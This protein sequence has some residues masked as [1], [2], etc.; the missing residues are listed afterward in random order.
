MRCSTTSSR[1]AIIPSGGFFGARACGENFRALLDIHPPYIDPVSSLAGGYMVNFLSYRE[2]AVESRFR[3]FPSARS[4]QNT[5]K[6][7][8]GIGAVQ[9]FCQ[10][11]T[12]GFTLGWGGCSRRSATI[13][14]ST[15]TMR[16]RSS[17]TAWSTSFSGCRAGSPATPHAARDM[18]AAEQDPQFR[19]NLLEIA[20]D[21][22]PAG[23]RA[24]ANVPR[25]LPVDALVSDGRKDVQHE[26]V[27]RPD[28]SVPL[29]VLRAGQGSRES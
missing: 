1:R 7:H 23:H 26:R 20:D 5:Y 16:P 25:G 15:R 14:R 21:Q 12:I 22:R 18:A 28:R 11:M 19:A 13:G 2:P 10:D 17:T 29:P 27:A 8:P 9:H 3:L 24:A 4:E 6:L